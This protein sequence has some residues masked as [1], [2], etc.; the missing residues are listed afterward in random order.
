MSWVKGLIVHNQDILYMAGE[1]VF[2][3]FDQG[4]EFKP[5]SGDLTHGAKEGDVAYGTIVS[6]HES[7]RVFGL[8]YAGSDDGYIHVTRDG[9]NNWAKISDKLPQSLWVSSIQASAHV[10]GRVYCS[11]NGYRWDH[12]DSYVYVSEDYGANWNRIVLTLPAEPVNV[13]KEDP[14]NPDILYIGTDHALYVSLDRGKTCMLLGDIPYAPVHDLAIHPRNKEIVT[15]THGRSFYKA[16]V[17][18]LQQL[19]AAMDSTSMTLFNEKLTTWHSERWGKRSADWME[20]SQPKVTYP[21]YS[22]ESGKGTLE[23]YADSLLI[24]SGDTEIR[25]GLSYY[26]YDLQMNEQNV[27]ALEDKLNS[28]DAKD[29]TVL[30]KSDDGKYY[31]PLGKYKLT[32]N[33]NNN[34]AETVLEVKKRG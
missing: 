17:K 19:K 5:I 22:K 13:V 23:V 18:H 28:G 7:P 34:K 31:L 2:R 29:K 33:L 27:K 12:F 16:N 10:D 3:S 4:N 30:K 11:L 8:L 24:Y 32:V 1:R 21:L 25:K 26:T 14:A 15:A 20:F 6:L 9:G